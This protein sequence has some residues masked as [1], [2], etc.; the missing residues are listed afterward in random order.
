M[1]YIPFVLL[2][3]ALTVALAGLLPGLHPKPPLARQEATTA[4]ADPAI[5]ALANAARKYDLNPV[6]FIAISRF[7]TA[8]TFSPM[9]GPGS[10]SAQGMCQMIAST[11]K[12]YGVKTAKYIRGISGPKILFM[13]KTAQQQADAC[14]RFT[15]DQIKAIRSMVG[16]KPTPGEIYLCHLQ[17]LGG[18]RRVLQ[19]AP[20]V[21]V[22][23]VT[24]KG[25]RKANGFIRRAKTAGGLR[26][27][28]SNMMRRQMAAVVVPSRD[29]CEAPF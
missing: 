27:A 6:L 17:G 15:R 4:R 10:S 25:A 5:I 13:I 21:S 9:I 2:G 18:C 22:S 24:S 7:E 12:A 3:L 29:V 16:R 26:I 8:K 14:A 20:G 19:A 1:K 28:A 11:R 23:K